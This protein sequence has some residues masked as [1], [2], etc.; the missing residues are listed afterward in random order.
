MFTSE[1]TESYT[2]LCRT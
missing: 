2:T 1:T